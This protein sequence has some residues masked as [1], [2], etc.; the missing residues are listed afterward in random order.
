[1]AINNPT[2]GLLIQLSPGRVSQ[3]CRVLWWC[4]VN[5]LKMSAWGWTKN[6]S[7]AFSTS[8]TAGRRARRMLAGHRGKE[9]GAPVGWL[10]WGTAWSRGQWKRLWTRW[11]PRLLPAGCVGEMPISG[12]RAEGF[13]VCR[14][15]PKNKKGERVRIT[16]LRH[17]TPL[18]LLNPLSAAAGARNSTCGAS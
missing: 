5:Y 10:F 15:S 13:G 16:Q 14:A 17:E 8:A 12:H 7:S 18:L 4:Q 6:F 3:I 2:P 11:T 9:S 1:M